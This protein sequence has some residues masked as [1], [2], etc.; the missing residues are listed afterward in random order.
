MSGANCPV[1]WHHTPEEQNPLTR[2]SFFHRLGIRNIQFH[3]EVRFNIYF[4]TLT[5]VLEMK[6]SNFQN[7][8]VKLPYSRNKKPKY[9][10]GLLFAYCSPRKC[11]A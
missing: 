1:T 10:N 9:N 2:N 4:Q 11:N 3:K 5:P 8:I 6:A 7:Y